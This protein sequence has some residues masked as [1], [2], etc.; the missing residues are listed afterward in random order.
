MTASDA[1]SDEGTAILIVGESEE[2][3]THAG[4]KH[5]LKPRGISTIGATG[6]R[7]HTSRSYWTHVSSYTLPTRILAVGGKSID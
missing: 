1:L 5:T 7:K 2:S 4:A 6:E 3:V